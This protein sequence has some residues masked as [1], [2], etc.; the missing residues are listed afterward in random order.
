MWEHV[1]GVIS[2]KQCQVGSVFSMLHRYGTQHCQLYW[3]CHMGGTHTLCEEICLPLYHA[4]MFVCLLL[5]LG[6]YRRLHHCW[7]IYSLQAWRLKYLYGLC[8]E[9]TGIMPFPLSVTALK[10]VLDYSHLYILTACQ[11]CSF[12]SLIETTFCCDILGVS[13]VSVIVTIGVSTIATLE[14]CQPL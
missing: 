10:Y 1:A 13:M 11:W 6:G 2:C 3:V 4:H 5:C 8:N 12:I 14:G 7:G 9:G